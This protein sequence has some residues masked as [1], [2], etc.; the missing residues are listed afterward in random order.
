MTDTFH[1]SSQDIG[2]PPLVSESERRLQQLREQRQII[3][4]EKELLEQQRELTQLKGTAIT[5]VTEATRPLD[6]SETRTE[7]GSF[8]TV[9]SRI[10]VYEAMNNI[11]GA[12][13]KDINGI[14]DMKALV[15]YDP[16]VFSAI[17]AY[18]LLKVKI[19]EF[20]G[21]YAELD[22][23]PDPPPSSRRSTRGIADFT[24][25][26]LPTTFTRSVLEFVA[27]FRSRD[28]IAFEP[29]FKL[30]P[31][32]LVSALASRFQKNDDSVKVYNPGFY[33]LSLTRTED[34]SLENLVGNEFSTLLR[35]RSKASRIPG[36]LS[37]EELNGDVDIFL[38]SLLFTDGKSDPYG[39]PPL[40]SIIQA[41][42]LEKILD[43]SGSYVLHLNIDVAGGSNRTR[44]SLFTTIFSGNRISFSG[45]SVVNYSLFARD[46]S[47]KKSDFYYYNTGYKGMKGRRTN[48]EN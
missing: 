17:T 16:E 24:P 33:A 29:D 36:G 10:L 20:Q 1:T 34:S 46:G 35:L 37:L 38:E 5:P 26:G 40:L 27:L 11:A 25:L 13:Y 8:Q 3:E 15:I 42:Q 6:A 14:S 12:I 7:Q 22:I 18:R 28:K 23:L 39:N 43:Q 4:A 19:A 44:S 2:I 45:G 21:R 48:I 41:N 32:S 31:N 30:N 47:L 9:E